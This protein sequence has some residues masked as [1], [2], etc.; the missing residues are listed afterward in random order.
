MHRFWFQPLLR[1]L[2]IAVIVLLVPLLAAAT[3]SGKRAFDERVGDIREQASVAAA[4]IATYMNSYLGSVDLLSTSLALHPDVHT[5]APA[6]AASLFAR[7]LP[8]QPALLNI[9]LVGADRELIAQVNDGPFAQKTDWAGAAMSSGR[10]VITGPDTEGSGDSRLLIGYPV[11]NPGGAVMGALGFRIR[12]RTIEE[13]LERLPLPNGSVVTLVDENGVILARTVA[14]ERYVGHKVSPDPRPPDR[15]PATEQVE[16][17]DGVRRMHA[18][19][20]VN[21]GPWVV[22]VGIPMNVALTKSAGLW[23]R[24]FVLLLV[25]LIGW[26]TV[27]VV[28][29][30][31][32]VRSVGHLETAA[33][34]VAAGDLGRLDPMPMP[35]RELF[36]LQQAFDLMVQ[37]LDEARQ[38]LDRQI[39]DERKMS[40]ELKSLQRQVI[41]QERLAAVGLL[42]SGVAHEINNPL[43]AI[44]GFA[45]LLQMQHRLPDS[46]AAAASSATSPCSRASSRAKPRTSALRT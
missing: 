37:R 5:L 41:R 22:S 13:L 46:V 18:N 17:V 31:R 15:V 9:I 33:K 4:T 3:W 23:G 10:R 26:V 34:R 39:A 24:S 19:A 2:L 44:L 7:T 12:L 45:E 32:F 6:G 25:A 38:A 20:I 1:Q 40:D 8:Q 43:Q 36:E 30:R 21:G 29:S 16:G 42:V 28:L 14:P 35:S 11:K 27:A